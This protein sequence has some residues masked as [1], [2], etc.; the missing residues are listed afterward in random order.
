[1]Q[2]LTKPTF[3]VTN[4]HVLGPLSDTFSLSATNPID[5]NARHVGKNKQSL[6]WQT[7]YSDLEGKI[8]LLKPSLGM[9]PATVYLHTTLQ[10]PKPQSARLLL[11]A[12]PQSKGWINGNLISW[13][14]TKEKS[15]FSEAAL[16]LQAGANELVIKVQP[17]KEHFTVVATLV[18]PEP[19]N[20]P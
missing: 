15:P 11:D 9:I 5:L 2:S 20:H 16:T 7:I 14:E 17:S 19:I 1:L 6:Q 13:S 4:W 3:T 12:T 18:S 10:S 8:D